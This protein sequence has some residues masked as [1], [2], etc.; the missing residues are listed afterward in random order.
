M[1][2]SDYIQTKQQI[3]ADNQGIELIGS[4]GD[5]GKRMYT[6]TLNENLF[7]PM[8]STVKQAFDEGD[9]KEINQEDGFPAKM[10][11]LHSS[12]ALA[13]NVFQYW[14]DKDISTIA[15]ACG[16]CNLNNPHPES[17]L[18]EKK[19]RIK[20][21]RGNPP[22]LDVVIENSGESYIKAYGIECKFTEA[23]S[24]RGSHG[25]NKKYLERPD[26]WE[27]IPN[28]H[29]FAR[30]ISPNDEV[31]NHLHPAQLIRHIL[32]LRG[33][34]GKQ[35][36]RLLYLWYDTLG[37]EGYKHKEELDI[38]TRICKADGVKFH[39]MTYQELISRLRINYLEEHSEYIKYLSNRYF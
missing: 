4:K 38:F 2:A 25:L 28:L 11:A 20:G 39:S 22:N 29:E 19:F 1:S 32:G 30:S 33:F 26:L 6:N 36:Y 3:W 31:F 34:Y 37:E 10:Q 23:Y 5:R 13:V 12:S 24:G 15:F 7:L 21:I 14:M 27:T 9:G 35:N 8:N 16:L 17:I 18:F